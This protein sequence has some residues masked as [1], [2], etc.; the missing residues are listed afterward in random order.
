MSNK[1]TLQDHNERLVY[2]N[3]KLLGILQAINELPKANN[4]DDEI[5]IIEE[6]VDLNTLNKTNISVKQDGTTAQYGGWFLYKTITLTNVKNIKYSNVPCYANPSNGLYLYAIVFY[7]EN[8]NFI[9]GIGKNEV[10]MDNIIKIN[11]GS[12]NACEY[13]ISDTIE[14]P[15]GAKYMDVASYTLQGVDYEPEIVLV[16][17][18]VS[19]DDEKEPIVIDAKT[20]ST[21]EQV[22]GKWID[23]RPLYRK[24]FVQP[25]SVSS[26]NITVSAITHN[27]LNIDNIWVGNESYYKDASGN[28]F[29]ANYND[30]TNGTVKRIRTVPGYT[31]CG[32]SVSANVFSDGNGNAYITFYYTKSTDSS[33][34]EILGTTNYSLDEQE[35]GTD[36]N[37]N[38][39][40]EKV[41]SATPSYSPN[42]GNKTATI[43]C[44]VDDTVT[45]IRL[46]DGFWYGLGTNSSTRSFYPLNFINSP[47]NLSRQFSSTS[48]INKAIKFIAGDWI[49][50]GN[51]LQFYAKIQYTKAV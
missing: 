49:T 7:N 36:I 14:V 27:I 12:S 26:G 29:S 46:V 40:Y 28:S 42:G 43:S 5:K 3:S 18:Q 33:T 31:D 48:V 37:G 34:E 47:S 32:I 8:G 45:N 6:T 4:S 15:S 21:E 38:T 25:F 50:T 13:L 2:N 24:T 23:N 51:R 41:I 1:E 17:E 9:S 22:V 39:I 35:V 19:N 30:A 10:S 11:T 44:N 16:K 20:Y